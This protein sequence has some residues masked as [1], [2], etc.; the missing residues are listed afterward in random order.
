M[1]LGGAD[2][3]PGSRTGLPVAVRVYRTPAP[4][5]GWLGHC[6]RLPCLPFLC[7]LL[8]FVTSDNWVQECRPHCSRVASFTLSTG[9]TFFQSTHNHASEN[10]AF[11]ALRKDHRGW[12]VRCV[13]RGPLAVG[14]SRGGRLYPHLP[15]V[16][17]RASAFGDAVASEMGPC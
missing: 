1:S 2:P 6:L 4:V 15:Q 11:P 9:T 7:G 14:D 10:T 5:R 12:G 8:W 17:R 13:P 16:G 3:V